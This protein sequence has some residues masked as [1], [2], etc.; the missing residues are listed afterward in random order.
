M[1]IPR[2]TFRLYD[3]VDP[4]LTAGRY[5]L[6]SRVNV[7]APDGDGGQA[8]LPVEGLD[9]VIN[10]TAPRFRLPPDQALQ[11]FPPANSE[12]AYE[13]R[14]PQI[15][16]KRRT[17]PWDRA[18]APV[19]TKFHG[20]RVLDRTPWLALVVIAEGEGQIVHDAEWRDCV[21]PGLQLEG[22]A[23]VARA[24]Y[25]SVPKSSIEK[26]FPTVDDLS[27]LTHVREVNLDD[28]ELAMGDDDG[29]LTV[30]I[31]NRMPQFDRENC[32]PKAYTACLINLEGQL[33]LLPKPEPP[34]L[35]FDITD[36][37]LTD[38]A[39]DY[40]AAVATGA[41]VMVTRSDEPRRLDPRDRDRL[42]DAVRRGEVVL[43][44]GALID[45]AGVTAEGL[46]RLGGISADDFL[47]G[48]FSSVIAIE[49]QPGG[50][51]LSSLSAS[52]LSTGSGAARAN[53]T[54]AD[55]QIY[56]I[57]GSFS[58][59]D[60]PLQKLVREQFYRFPV[61]TS[62]RF[63]CS[64]AGSFEQLMRD[65]DVGLLGTKA[66]GGYQRPLPDCA[67]PTG[68]A[69]EPGAAPV[70]RMPL[71]IAETGHIGMP[72]VTR[73]GIG[74]EA[75][76]RGPLSPHRLLRNPLAEEGALPVLAHIS[77]HLRM[78]TPEGREDVS[79]AV[80]FETGRLL[81]LSQPAF[82]AA[83]Q[84]WRA[85]AFG[86]ARAKLDQKISIVDRMPL[87]HELTGLSN[88]ARLLDALSRGSLPSELRGVLVGGIDRLRDQTI[89]ETRPLVDPALIVP[90]LQSDS[91][92]LLADGLGL[93]RALLQSVANDPASSASF[94][95]L[96]RADPGLV[97]SDELTL[98]PALDAQLEATLDTGL[99]RMAETA[100]GREVLDSGKPD[101]IKRFESLDEFIKNR[102]E[103]GR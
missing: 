83:M 84:R 3:S 17:L 35:F 18:A 26:L 16:L 33:G 95:A 88:A 71:E 28:T 54:A 100:V 21:T 46:N 45:R 24:S 53:A 76:Y 69:S 73:T 4:A 82:I 15:V 79:L 68:N 48:D 90:A 77:D 27:L 52:T 13:E 49:A 91:A 47:N 22:D 96:Q 80:A 39:R 70:T 78:M 41:P 66:E 20:Q 51:G 63:T 6:R 64:G 40:A 44:D 94:Q 14:L 43:H 97:A 92:T 7:E 2:G 62:W 11:V 37:V 29:F 65:L 38:A 75:W 72:H 19:G 93:D 60:F 10:V 81:A 42:M 61:L 12:G 58:N 103:E 1:A 101:L 74:K 25:L 34:R 5:T 89:A 86:A 32:R 67:Q 85:E 57:E 8:D 31:A 36:L 102:F 56:R 59:F 55:A 30:V 50:G 99:G 98:G 9:T 23:D 87:L